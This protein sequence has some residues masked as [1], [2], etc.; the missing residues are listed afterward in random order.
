[1]LT[2]SNPMSVA[3]GLRPTLFHLNRRLRKELAPLGVTGGQASLLW[4]IR[5]SPGIGVRELAEREGVSP[6][7]MTAYVDR[8]EAAGF[9]A[10]RR[11]ERDRRRVE[12]DLTEDG[13]RVLRSVRSRRTAWLAA[14]LRRLEPDELEAIERALPAL[15]RLTEDGT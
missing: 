6:P 12:L 7:A 1:M 13:A 14:R 2:T 15:R 5:T 10:R 3:N 8:L 9:V 4:A 11:S